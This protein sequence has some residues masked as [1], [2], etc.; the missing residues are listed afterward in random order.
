[1]DDEDEP[2]SDEE[3]LYEGDSDQVIQMKGNMKVS[4]TVNFEQVSLLMKENVIMR[5]V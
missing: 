3:L 2:I 5:T 4:E 1:M